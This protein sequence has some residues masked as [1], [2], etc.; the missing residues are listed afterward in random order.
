[1]R[2]KSFTLIEDW[3][4]FAMGIIAQGEIKGQDYKSVLEPKHKKVLVEWKGINLLLVIQ[5]DM[6]DF[7]LDAWGRMQKSTLNTF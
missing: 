4:P 7:N 1:M 6:K 5:A 2:L 3:R